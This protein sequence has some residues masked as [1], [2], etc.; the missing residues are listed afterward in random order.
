MKGF[1]EQQASIDLFNCFHLFVQ[2]EILVA[3]SS[4]LATG[5]R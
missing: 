1:S 5:F 2:Y 3:S 4:K